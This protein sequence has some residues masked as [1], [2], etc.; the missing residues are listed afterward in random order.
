MKILSIDS[1]IIHAGVAAAVLIFFSAVY[2]APVLAHAFP[3]HAEPR[4]GSKVAS[5]PAKVTIWFD[6]AI[7]EAFSK[8]EVYD[9]AKQRVDKND[10]RVDPAN[11]TKLEVTLSPLPPGT[12]H[13]HWTVLSVDTHVT[14]GTFMFTVGR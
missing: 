14:E 1:R 9:S 5:A 7:E 3:T 11:R 10:A 4:V 6:D 13:V 8:I 12:Y 2:A